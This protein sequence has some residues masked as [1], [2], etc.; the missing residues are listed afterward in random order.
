MVSEKAYSQW[1]TGP[2]SI[3]FETRN[4]GF[5][6]EGIISGLNLEVSTP[7]ASNPDFK[8]KGSVNVNSLSTHNHAR[9]HHLMQA[10]YFDVATYPK[11]NLESVSIKKGA[12]NNYQ[13]VFKL[14]IKDI[15][16]TIQFPFQYKE[17]IPNQK[18]HL[19]GDF[20]INRR[21]FHIGGSS[22]ILSDSIHI[23]IQINLVQ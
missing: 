1:K 20:K 21:D 12:G 6:V 7:T 2:Y 4:A 9:D 10:D 16:K 3:N 14:G 15:I 22:F 19:S 8:L 5:K 11:I 18:A 13:G 17:D 23:R